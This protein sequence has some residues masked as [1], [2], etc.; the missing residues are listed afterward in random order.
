MRKVP[1]QQHEEQGNPGDQQNNRQIEQQPAGEGAYDPYRREI[2]E[3]VFAG[4]G[5]AFFGVWRE[6]A[7]LDRRVVSRFP[8]S[9]GLP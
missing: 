1:R 2:V 4:S 7:R 5:L 8:A 9:G 3:Q 6:H